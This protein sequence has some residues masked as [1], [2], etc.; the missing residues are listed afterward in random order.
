MTPE[1]LIEIMAIGIADNS[2]SSVCDWEWCVPENKQAYLDEARAALDAI[3]S[4]GLLVVYPYSRGVGM[5]SEG[6]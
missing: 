3:E 6:E 1:E 2:E 5:K 4:A